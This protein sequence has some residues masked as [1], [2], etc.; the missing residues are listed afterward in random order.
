MIQVD[1][2][3]Q[4]DFRVNTKEDIKMI[5]PYGFGL[6]FVGQTTIKPITAV[7]A[8][9][10]HGRLVETIMLMVNHLISYEGSQYVLSWRNSNIA[11]YKP[12]VTEKKKQMDFDEYLDE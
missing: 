1:G 8:H 11:Y 10:L 4:V 2:E 12:A 9:P 3:G 5:D 7:L 6:D